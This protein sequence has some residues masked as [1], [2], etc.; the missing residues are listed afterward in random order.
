MYSRSLMNSF[1]CGQSGPQPAVV[2]LQVFALDSGGCS[3]WFL[4]KL[5]PLHFTSHNLGLCRN[6]SSNKSEVMMS[7]FDG[8]NWAFPAHR[9]TATGKLRK[10]QNSI[11]SSFHKS[12][13]LYTFFCFKPKVYFS[14]LYV[15]LQHFTVYHM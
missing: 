8:V 3:Q 14:L 2:L 4:S 13:F 5:D 9:S 7:A 12:S 15:S 10:S 1:Y 11:L 6:Q